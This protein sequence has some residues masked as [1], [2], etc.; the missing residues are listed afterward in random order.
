[1]TKRLHNFTVRLDDDE[2]TLIELLAYKYRTTQADIMRCALHQYLERQ[3][4]NKFKVGDIFVVKT[5][6]PFYSIAKIDE[7]GVFTQG[8]NYFTFKEII[9]LKE[10]THD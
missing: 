8:G 1:M 2:K 10:Y 6:L 7:Y 9:N 5:S 3:M 4:P